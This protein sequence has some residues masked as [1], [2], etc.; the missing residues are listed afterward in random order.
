MSE[1]WTLTELGEIA[2]PVRGISYRSEDYGS[3]TDGRPFLTLKCVQ[4]NGGYSQ[5]G[6]KFYKGAVE[7]DQLAP[8]G[9]LL[10][11]CTDLTRDRAVLGSP[12]LVPT[13][14][15]PAPS[16]FSL[17]LCKLVP[18]QKQATPIFLFYLLMAPAS[19]NYLKVRSSGTTVMHLD[20]KSAMKMPVRLPPLEEQR[21]MVDFLQAV[22]RLATAADEVA[23]RTRQF[24]VTVLGEMMSGTRRL[25]ANYERLME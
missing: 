4:R 13:L 22:D 11:A 3:E 5:D 18:D 10:M 8:P 2:A 21:R 25:P 17:D 12:L 16:C 9:S 23:L 24:R 20:L 19:R 1:G 7:Q 14:A 15:Y 6:L